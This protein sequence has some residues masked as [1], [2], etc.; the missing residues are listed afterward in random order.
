MRISPLNLKEKRYSIIFLVVLLT[1]GA[2]DY[3]ISNHPSN[4]SISNQ[5]TNMEQAIELH[6]DCKIDKSDYSLIVWHQKLH[7]TYDSATVNRPSKLYVEQFLSSNFT[8]FQYVD[9]FRID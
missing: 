1:I 6:F 8:D 2:S 3:L 9:E 4:Q 7:F 5:L